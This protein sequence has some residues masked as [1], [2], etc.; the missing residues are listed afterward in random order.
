MPGEKIS[1]EIVELIKR[2]KNLHVLGVADKTLSTIKVV[3]IE[4]VITKFPC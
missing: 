2:E 1:E 4:P 3:H